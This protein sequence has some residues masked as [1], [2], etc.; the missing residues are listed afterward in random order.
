MS[1]FGP[2]VPT[3]QWPDVLQYS[4]MDLQE[5]Y[6]TGG[7]R[8]KAAEA[9]RAACGIKDPSPSQ[10]PFSPYTSTLPI[11]GVTSGCLWSSMN[12]GVVPRGVQIVSKIPPQP[13]PGPS[14]LQQWIQTSNGHESDG[15]VGYAVGT[16]VK[17]CHLL[18]PEVQRYNSLVGDIV[19]IHDQMRE[20]GKSDLLFD[21]RC[22]C[23]EA[24]LIG[25]SADMMNS[26]HLT[27]PTSEHSKLAVPSNRVLV[28][29]MYGVMASEAKAH[30]DERL[31]PFVLLSRLPSEKLEP[32][33]TEKPT[34][35]SDS[36]RPV[37]VRPPIW[38]AAMEPVFEE[39]QP[40]AEP[41]NQV[42]WLRQQGYHQRPD[43]Q[44]Y[45]PPLPVLR[46]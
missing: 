41:F 34:R 38:G 11:P 2:E 13:G 36:S 39:R 9:N 31:P 29:P 12:Y 1:R 33:M 23:Q 32:I 16:P 37:T 30:D 43:G 3:P 8:Y 5:R 28:A 20:D 18:S 10:H 24:K 21:I 27:V 26:E 4:P 25:A 44:W 15:P 17:I 40:V 45:A 7:D 19:C 35:P 6:A 42:E 14:P 22:P 46:R